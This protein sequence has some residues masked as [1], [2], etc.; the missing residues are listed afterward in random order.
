MFTQPAVV[1]W[2]IF[3]GA[4][5]KSGLVAKRSSLA[6][7]LDPL[8]KADGALPC[9]ERVSKWIVLVSSLLWFLS[10]MWVR[11][12]LS[13]LSNSRFA[14]CSRLNA[15]AEM[16]RPYVVWAKTYLPNP[17]PDWNGW[18]ACSGCENRQVLYRLSLVGLCQ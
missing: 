12:T 15:L 16:K 7:I 1:F 9:L 8:A 4:P 3:A 6:R 18:S 2:I 10:Q 11:T 14:L 17:H 13:R 5:G